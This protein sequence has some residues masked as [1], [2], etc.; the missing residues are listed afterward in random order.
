[1]VLLICSFIH[2]FLVILTL[3]CIGVLVEPFIPNSLL[4]ARSMFSVSVQILPFL[5]RVSVLY[6]KSSFFFVLWS[7]VIKLY[8]LKLRGNV[9]LLCNSLSLLA[10]REGDRAKRQALCGV[11][12]FRT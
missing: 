8:N 4:T 2:V 11:E 10:R 7:V 12:V 6:V 1:M 9:L 5:S 3:M